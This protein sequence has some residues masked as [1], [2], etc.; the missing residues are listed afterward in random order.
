MRSGPGRRPRSIRGTRRD[1][2]DDEERDSE[3]STSFLGGDDD[4]YRPGHVRAQ[5]SLSSNGSSTTREL[6]SK[7][8]SRRQRAARYVGE[9]SAEE[10]ESGGGQ[11]HVI[12]RL[13]TSNVRRAVESPI[14]REEP[15]DGGGGGG[16]GLDAHAGSQ[17]VWLAYSKLMA[18]CSLRLITTLIRCSCFFL[19][20]PSGFFFE[21]GGRSRGC[22][23]LTRFGLLGKTVR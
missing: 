18:S 12:G 9:E 20:P 22:G 7:L 15:C 5:A 17:K 21:G 6:A 4:D 8:R 13:Q 1:T 2:D 10:S 23:R 14:E 3:D 11:G 19:F 16:A